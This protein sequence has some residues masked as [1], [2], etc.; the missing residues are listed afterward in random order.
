MKDAV[1]KKIQVGS[2]W[3]LT[4]LLLLLAAGLAFSWRSDQLEPE[5]AV[6]ESMSQAVMESVS[7]EAVYGK[8][9]GEDTG[10]TAPVVVY[11]GKKYR[12]RKDISTLLL[13]GLDVNG[14]EERLEEMS[15]RQQADFLMLLGVDNVHKKGFALHINRDTMTDVMTKD[16]QGASAGRQYMQICL[17]HN[18]GKD[19][20]SSC[21]NTVDAAENLLY[22]TR[23]D[24]YLCTT[25][26]SVAYLNDA[27]G[28]VELVCLADF[29]GDSA[30]KTGKKIVLRGPRALTYVRARMGMPDETNLSRM[31]R[32]QQY[33]EELRKVFTAKS[34]E[35]AG[36]LFESL[37][38]ISENMVSDCTISELSDIAN[39]ALNYDF[40]KILTVKG[41]NREGGIYTEYYPDEEALQQQIIDLFYEEMP[42]EQP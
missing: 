5:A 17:S 14:L 25:M 42:Q 1:N 12:Q 23:I 41:E 11:H 38:A 7:D 21:E 2:P 10:S 8:W 34:R 16:I 24:H 30:M 9:R 40:G 39:A 6:L 27:V 28:G 15:N 33:L 31:E 3:L 29:P 37:Y 32:Q 35:D 36:F 22:N 13:I 4:I 19:E 18:Y 20:A 26:D